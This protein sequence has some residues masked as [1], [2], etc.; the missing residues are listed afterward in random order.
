[1]LLKR[2]KSIS[3]FRKKAK[4]YEFSVDYKNHLALKSRLL[5]II[6]KTINAFGLQFRNKPF[7]TTIPR[8]GLFRLYQAVN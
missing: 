8:K 7:Q 2:L 6:L 4:K 5:Q 1:M 3:D